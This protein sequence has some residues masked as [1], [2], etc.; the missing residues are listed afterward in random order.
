MIRG[1]V[2]PNQRNQPPISPSR[3]CFLTPLQRLTRLSHSCAN[4]KFPFRPNEVAGVAVGKLL[5]VIL[6]LGL[7]FPERPRGR[8]F[9]DRFA[10]PQAG[11]VHVGNGVERGALLLFVR[12]VNRGTIAQPAVIALPVHGG[13]V[14][15]LK[16][17]FQNLA[18]ADLRWVENN[19]DRFGVRAV[20]AIG[21][22]GHVAAGIADARGDHTRL[23]AQQILHAP[24]TTTGQNRFFRL[25]TH[26][27][28]PFS[29]A[30]SFSAPSNNLRY[31]P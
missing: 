15:N 24:E 13:G 5:Q 3:F 27:L 8:Y 9:G 19:L 29:F 18:I 17:E 10:G 6:M 4:R 26:A 11:G 22:V 20:I 7:S 21:R 31:A 30:L 2:R 16:K 12:V 1:L 23:L 28:A 25:S 14:V